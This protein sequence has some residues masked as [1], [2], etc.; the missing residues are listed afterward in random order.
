MPQFPEDKTKEK[1]EEL[2]RKEEEQSIQL[3]SAKYKLPYLNLSTFPVELDALALVPEEKA[4]FASLVVIQ[5]IGKKIKVAVRNPDKTETRLVLDKLASNGFESELFLVSDHSLERAW[6]YYSNLHEAVTTET[7]V[8]SVHESKIN[9]LSG[10]L[11]TLEEVRLSLNKAFGSATTEVLEILIAG[12]LSL[13][14]SDIHIEPQKESTRT[15][16]RLDGVLQDLINVPTKIYNLLLSRI[17]LLSELKLNIHDRAQDGRFTIKTPDAEIEV[18]TSTLP[19]PYGE[20]VVLRILNP[21]TLAVK[22]EDLGMRSEIIEAMEQELKK[23][24]GMIL[25]TG[26]TGSGKTTTLYAFLKKVHTPEIKIITLEDPIEYHL[27]GMEQTQVDADKG[28]D[29]ASGLRAILRQ[30]PD[31]ILVGEIRDKETAETA[32]NAALTG[33]LVFSTLHTNNAAATIPRLL[34]LGVK[35]AVIAP[36]LNVIMAQ[37]LVRKLCLECRKKMDLSP[38]EK[39]KL[40]KELNLFPK[41][42]ETPKSE[43]WEIYESSG[44]GCGKCNQGYKSRTGVREIILIDD[45]LEELILRQPTELEIKKASFEQGQLNLRQD[46]LLKVLSG[47]TDFAELEKVVGI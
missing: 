46:G 27:V 17:K 1:L 13:D 44:S 47:I 34:D 33:H 45:K 16:Y 21:K 18:R 19:G 29:F 24:N 20:N 14:G 37:R 12:A 2:R 25:T 7:G 31:V 9:S 15:R 6:S 38:A 35:P 10:Q 36:A 41:S 11:K 26:P 4:R 3:L 42:K 23:P 22:F 28:Y 32:M 8:V 5:M 30:D 43:K 40:E 39:E